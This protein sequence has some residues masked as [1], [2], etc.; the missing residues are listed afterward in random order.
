[1]QHPLDT[2]TIST[3]Q[4]R[5]LNWQQQHGRHHLPWQHQ[6]T[7]YKVHVSEI[8]LQQTQVA[9]V[10]PYFERW[11]QSFPALPVLA[12]ASED[13]VMAHWQ[14]LGYYSRARNLRK[15]AAYIVEQHQGQYPDGLA[16]LNAIPG[17]GRYTAGAIRSFAF[18]QYGPIV[19]GNV[20]RLYARLFALDG[21]PTRSAFINSL[22]HYADALTP[23]RNSRQFSQGVLDLGAT[24]CRKS[25]P[26][27]PECPLQAHCL[28]FLHNRVAELPQKKQRKAK[29][30][31]D[32][33][34]LWQ[35]DGQN[36]ST[37]L[38]LQKRSSPGIWGGLWCLPEL[39]QPPQNATLAGEFTHEFSHYR[40]HAK[41]WCATQP[42]MA[43]PSPLTQQAV[44]LNALDNIGLP[45]P[46]RQFIEDR[47]ALTLPLSLKLQ[48]S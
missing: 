17:V 4:R 36:Q 43:E 5:V 2:L 9:T 6:V 31:R 18:N 33:H 39:N 1:M 46:I 15:A 48:T 24:V 14:G 12:A 11:M 23:A 41:V 22:W 21:D 26:D 20:K 16:A 28:A 34:F 35:S 29:P 13:D 38:I 8:M 45:T 40:L 27:C 7:P 3:L 44:K 42:E 32:G 47:L 10:I 30:T 25:S 37:T 19:D